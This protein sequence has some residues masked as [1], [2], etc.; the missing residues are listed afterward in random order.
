MGDNDRRQLALNDSEVYDALLG[1]ERRHL[2]KAGRDPEE[3][4]AGSAA[5]G[6]E[7]RIG[8]DD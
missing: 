8:F 1:E 3:I 4:C 6:A 2:A 5:V 7:A